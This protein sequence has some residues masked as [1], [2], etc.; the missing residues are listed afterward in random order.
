VDGNALA[1]LVADQHKSVNLFVFA[2]NDIESHAG[3]MLI[4]KVL[5]LSYRRLCMYVWVCAYCFVY[6]SRL[7]C[8]W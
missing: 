7:R 3:Q 1:F 4:C 8:T 2:P 6:L 5:C